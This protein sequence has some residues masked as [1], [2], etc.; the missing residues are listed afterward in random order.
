MLPQKSDREPIES[1]ENA[2]EEVGG[3]VG[4][5]IA[6]GNTPLSDNPPLSDETESVSGVETGTTAVLQLIVMGTPEDGGRSSTTV[7]KR[8]LTVE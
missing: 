3:G 8:V 5:G 4:N 6:E 2:D 7:G 1:A